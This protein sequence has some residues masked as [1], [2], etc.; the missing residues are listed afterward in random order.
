MLIS[1]V[2][3]LQGLFEILQMTGSFRMAE[4][5]QRRTSG[6]SVSLAGPDDLIL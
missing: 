5:G 2:S 3:D 1:L 4:E 6:L